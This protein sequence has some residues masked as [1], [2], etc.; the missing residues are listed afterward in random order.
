[1]EEDDN[2]RLMR[3]MAMY[4][5]MMQPDRVVGPDGQPVTNPNVMPIPNSIPGAIFEMARPLE[6]VQR[7]RA[8]GFNDSTQNPYVLRDGFGQRQMIPYLLMNRRWRT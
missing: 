4:R 7:D 6:N 3:A 5:E 1:M 8:S 2:N